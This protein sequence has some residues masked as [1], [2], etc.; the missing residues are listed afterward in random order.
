[1]LMPRPAR[2]NCVFIHITLY[3]MGSSITKNLMGF[4]VLIVLAFLVGIM[5]ADSAKS[6][7]LIIFGVVGLAGVVAMGRHVWV[8]MFILV[9]IGQAIPVY[10]LPWYF[11]FITVLLIYWCML[12]VVGHARFTW[13][14][15][16][17]A[18][19]FVF[20][21]L[22]Y[23]GVTIFRHPA[24]STIINNF[25][26]IKTD[27]VTTGLEYP[28]TFAVLFFYIAYSCIPFEKKHLLKVIHWG[29][30][31]KLVLLFVSAIAGY[32]A[33]VEETNVNVFFNSWAGERVRFGMFTTFATNMCV[34][35][36][37]SAPVRQVLQSPSKLFLILLSLV[38]V[39]FSGYRNR[40][41]R[42]GI[43]MIGVLIIKKEYMLILACFFT[44]VFSIIFINQTNLIDSLPYTIQR[45]VAGIPGVKVDTKIK[46]ET[47]GSNEWRFVM[48]R[49]ALDPRTNY[50]HDYIWGD[51]CTLNTREHARTHRAAARGT[52]DVK[53]QENQAFIRAWHS[54]FIATIQELGI[55]GLCLTFIGHIYG[56]V[57]TIRIGTALRKTPYLK[58]FLVYTCTLLQ[59]I[60][61]FYILP[62]ST[63]NFLINL[64][65]FGYLKVFYH[66]GVDNGYILPNQRKRHYT[67]L[68]I[69]QEA[70]A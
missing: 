52:Y 25:L 19:L 21:F 61:T 59:N 62:A 53:S 30:M 3:I 28:L 32:N 50:I 40:L 58:Y 45:T 17:G 42:L 9:P 14:K 36:Y 20:T 26:G 55:V 70:A 56:F 35:V 39:V 29:V 15:L 66:I 12:S 22:A 13:R 27:L 65:Y 49:W 5:A 8:L 68:L 69:E 2:H 43:I 67:P 57:M 54:G 48:W 60:I 6:A 24:S 4:L 37:A 41:M 7:A 47:S 18:D 31:L 51:G 44:A 11:V 64:A 34:Y 1:M 16:P 38:L 63:Q 46:N 10:Q 23:M 33:Q